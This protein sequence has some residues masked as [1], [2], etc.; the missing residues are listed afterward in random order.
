MITAAVACD[1]YIECHDGSDENW[2]CENISFVTWFGVAA[3]L[4][5]IM[6][7]ELFYKFATKKKN[8]FSEKTF[9]DLKIAEDAFQEHFD[10]NTEKKLNAILLRIHLSKERED[11]ITTNST[12]FKCELDRHQQNFAMTVCHIKSYLH[13]SICKVVLKDCFPGLM[14]LYFPSVE[15]CIDKLKKSN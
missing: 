10:Q 15:D 7:I 5:L 12:Y 1:G 14:R 13:G 3:C 8:N 4:L 6:V 11:R 2:M 9:C